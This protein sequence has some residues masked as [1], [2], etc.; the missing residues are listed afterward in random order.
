MFVYQNKFIDTSRITHAWIDEYDGES[1][2][3]VVLDSEVSIELDEMSAE[4]ALSL[5]N[6]IYEYKRAD[7]E[8]RQL[9]V[10]SMPEE[11]LGPETRMIKKKRRTNESSKS[12]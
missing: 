8:N 9:P 5:L 6:F 10:W 4:T 11:S 12:I 2:L 3:N 1:A 7:I